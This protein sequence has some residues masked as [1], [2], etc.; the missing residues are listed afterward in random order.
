MVT[1]FLKKYSQPLIIFLVCVL[2]FGLQVFWM[3]YYIDDWV[4]LNDYSA[5]GF[6]GLRLYAY[7]DSRPLVFWIWWIGFQVNRF[8]PALW[9]IWAALWRF[10]SVGALWMTLRE[11]WPQHRRQVLL[12]SLLFAVYPIFMQQPTALTYSFHWI[13][14]TLFFVSLYFTVLSIK[15]PEKYGRYTL[16]AVLLGSVQLFSQEFFVGLELFRPFVIWYLQNGAGQPV[17]TRVRRVV[18]AWLPYVLVMCLYGVWRF[19]LMPAT[20]A[21][22]NAPQLLEGLKSNPLGAI[23]T[24]VQYAMQDIL[25]GVLGAWYKTIQPDQFRLTPISSRV[26]LALIGLTFVI[27]VVVLLRIFKNIEEAGAPESS[28]WYRS[29]IPLG[30][31]AMVTGFAP[32]WAI[33]RQ[34]SDTSGLFNDRF[35]LAAMVGAALIVTAIVD[36]IVQNRKQQVVIYSLLIALAVGAQFRK[37]TDYRHSWEQQVRFAWQLSWRAPQLKAPTA[38]FAEGTQFPFMGGFPNK[39][40]INQIYAFNQDSPQTQFWFFDIFKTDPTPFLTGQAPIAES[41][42]I[43]TYSG[44]INYNLVVQYNS[45]QDQCLWVLSADDVHNPYITQQI[46][47][48]IPLGNLD[49]I[50]EGKPAIPTELF[51]QEP[52]PYWCYYYEKGALAAQFSQ[53]DKAVRLWKEAQQKGFKPSVGIEYLPF[54]QAA[55]FTGDWQL[56]DDITHKANYPASQMNDSLCATWKKISQNAVGSKEKDA[57]ME[58]I[59]GLLACH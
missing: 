45:D 19:A 44:A 31:V 9:Q 54:I 55:A 27:L 4:I 25:N 59:N 46:K 12:A 29:A 23:V 52:A 21:D 56:A 2:A 34:Y 42:N 13:C 17:K 43:M 20:G 1:S 48:I 30:F 3:G 51:G 37:E 38:I 57:A 15:R 50:V 28:A 39:A 36:W 32:G 10:L 26:T 58:S 8:T 35:G 40:Y 41:R 18:Q 33:G 24:L 22:R 6:E 11:I 47:N 49:R 16:L 53:W 14:F 5:K 7:L